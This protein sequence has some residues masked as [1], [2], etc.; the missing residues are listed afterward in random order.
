[1][2]AIKILLF[3]LIFS[4]IFIALYLS[5]FFYYTKIAACLPP[6]N[7]HPDGKVYSVAFVWED[8][9]RDGYYDE[10][11]PAMPGVTVAHPLTLD[12]SGLTNDKGLAETIEYKG[13]CPCDCWV[14]SYIEVVT[15]NGYTATTPPKQ[16]LTGEGVTLLFGFAKLN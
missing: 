15:P 5:G 9:N 11:E 4:V 10:G 2:K 16:L 7:I 1:M 13:G 12:V 8:Q 6:P 14:G 3:L